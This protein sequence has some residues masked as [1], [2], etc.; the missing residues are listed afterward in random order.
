[1]GLGGLVPSVLRD[2]Q[3]VG[4][5]TVLDKHI[6]GQDRP[7]LGTQVPDVHVAVPPDAHRQCLGSARD[8]QHLS[9]GDAEAQPTPYS[10]SREC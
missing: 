9:E 10:H 1:M 3:P 7:I 2:G 6:E 4:A 8:L 5:D